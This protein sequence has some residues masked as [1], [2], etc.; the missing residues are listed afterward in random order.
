MPRYTDTYIQ[1]LTG[2]AD[3]QAKSLRDIG[4]INAR[5]VAGNAD[6]LAQTTAA[7][8]KV[9]GALPG[10]IVGIASGAYDQYQQDRRAQ[11]TARIA[12]ERIAVDQRRVGVAEQQAENAGAALQ[13]TA[14]RQLNADTLAAQKAK[15]E[16]ALKMLPIISP[17]ITDTV[18]GITEANWPTKRGLLRNYAVLIDPDEG[19]AWFDKTVPE[20]FTPDTV[21]M[22]TKIAEG[23]ANQSASTA[24]PMSIPTVDE[25]GN[26][27]TKIVPRNQAPGTYPAQPK[28]APLL[29]PPRPGTLEYDVV[30]AEKAKGAPLTQDEIDALKRRNRD[31]TTRPPASTTSA[32]DSD[33]AGLLPPDPMSSDIL[34]QTGLNLNAFMWLTGRGTQLSRDAATRKKAAQEAQDWARQRGVDV[35]T[36]ASQYKTYNDVLSAN[37]ARLNNT[38]IMEG[39]LEGTIQN[40]QKVASDADLSRLRFANVLKVWAGQEVNDSLA[41]QYAL[42]LGQLRN[43]LSAYYAATQGR[44]GN[45][46]TLQDQNDASLVIRN[47]VAKGSLAG[48]AEAVKNSTDK[49]GKVMDD[50]VSRAQK[51]VWSLFGVGQNYK[52]KPSAASGLVKVGDTVTV[53]GKQYTVGK[54]YPDG[55]WDPK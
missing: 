31:N 45:N 18:Q 10:Q 55:T 26:P 53:K 33:A 29:A 48:L 13:N 49:M 54:V 6:V 9:W 35:S 1:L 42:H 40:I 51:S 34:S 37:I 17:H 32:S 44:T 12:G 46:I 25:N 27:V 43:E 30:Q 28:E 24:A 36:M 23:I 39:E 11:E 20:P 3:D 15:Q 38:K 22:V 19:G 52:D 2:A 41:Q 8:A 7:N 50:S 47:G 5:T 16:H 14:D 4:A 21:Q